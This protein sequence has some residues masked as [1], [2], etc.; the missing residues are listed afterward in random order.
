M[1]LH[2]DAFSLIELIIVIAIIGILAAIAVPVYKSYSFKAQI[3]SLIPAMSN[4]IDQQMAAFSTKGYVP[5]GQQLG[6]A[7]TGYGPNSGDTN[8]MTVNALGNSALSNTTSF[9]YA[10]GN[11]NSCVT[12]LIVQTY[13]PGTSTLAFNDLPIW[14]NIRY[15]HF[16]DGTVKKYYT[17]NY[18]VSQAADG[19]IL[20][21]WVNM[22]ST[23]DPL[24]TQYQT[25]WANAT[26]F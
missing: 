10:P 16:A 26:C 13:I 11:T 23:T 18:G 21:G 5:S 4:I 15:I 24:A 2:N 22:A 1:K 8:F 25:E 6:Y 3:N 20:P 9:V 7:A 19:D 12:G 14:L 17:Y